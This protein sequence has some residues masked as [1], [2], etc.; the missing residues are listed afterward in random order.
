MNSKIYVGQVN[1][2]RYIPH[3]HAFSYNMFMMYLDLDELPGLFDGFLLWSARR[4]NIA[5]FKRHDHLGDPS[6]SLKQSVFKLVEQQTAIRLD[7]PVRL[8]THLRYFGYGFNPVSFYYCFDNEGR[9]IRVI[10]AEVNNTPWGEQYCY[11]LPVDVNEQSTGTFN[12]SLDKQ[13]HVSPFNP[14]NQEYNWNFSHPGDQLG[15]HMENWQHQ[16]KVFDASLT[17][18]AREISSASLARA[19]L[20]FPLMT[21][22]VT[23]SIYFQALKLLIKRT[24]IYTHPDKLITDTSKTDEVKS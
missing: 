17:M 6:R 15:V 18:K 12:F 2:H 16:Q 21:A 10:V 23:F 19:L 22:K 11:V 24:P 3:E 20:H 4:F 9:N 7:G 1:H 14:M 5:S 8:L 13:F